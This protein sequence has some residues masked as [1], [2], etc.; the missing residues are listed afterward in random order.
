MAANLPPALVKKILNRVKKDLEVS[1]AEEDKVF[2]GMGIKVKTEVDK[3]KLGRRAWFARHCGMRMVWIKVYLNHYNFSNCHNPSHDKVIK[4][5]RTNGELACV[6]A[7]CSYH[8][9][10]TSFS[11]MAG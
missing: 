4:G 2:Q 1:I 5:K 3:V 11:G 9:T 8:Y 10:T 7:D 6:C